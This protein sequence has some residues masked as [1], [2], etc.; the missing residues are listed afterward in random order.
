VTVDLGESFTLA[1]ETTNI[2]SDNTL[3][4]NV[5]V[6]SSTSNYS[7]WI[8]IGGAGYVVNPEQKAEVTLLSSQQECEAL[9]PP[10]TS[11]CPQGPQYYPV[12]SILNDGESRAF[13][14]V[15]NGNTSSSVDLKEGDSFKIKVHAIRAIPYPNKEIVTA[16]S[17]VITLIR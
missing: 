12:I 13:F 15:I 8:K 11:R 6:A 5:S 9:H 17:P 7:Q 14:Y 4:F 16:V 2:V 3:L 10:A 1:W